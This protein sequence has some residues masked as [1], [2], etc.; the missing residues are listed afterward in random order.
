[1][2]EHVWSLPPHPFLPF[3]I[4][5]TVLRAT[6]VDFHDSRSQE[7][8]T[9]LWTCVRLVS[10]Q[11]KNEVEDIFKTQHLPRTVLHFIT[12]QWCLSCACP[13][14]PCNQEFL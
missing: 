12:G 7:D 3:E 9:H 13:Q 1:M 2:S 4:W 11:L 10:K 6:R 14:L 8:L 5:D